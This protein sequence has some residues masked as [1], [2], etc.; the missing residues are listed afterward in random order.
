MAGLFEH[1]VG[2]P[3]E[4]D[5]LERCNCR[6]AGALGHQFCGWNDEKNLPQFMVGPLPLFWHDKEL[7]LQPLNQIPLVVADF[8]RQWPKLK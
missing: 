6:F 1:Y 5:D 8:E 3:P 4:D 2:C 7:E